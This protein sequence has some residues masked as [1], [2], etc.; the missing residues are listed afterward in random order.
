[1]RDSTIFEI[2]VREVINHCEWANIAYSGIDKSGGQEAVQTFFFVQTFMAHCATVARLLWSPEFAEHAGGRTIAKV[3]EVPPVYRL[4]DETV[5]EIVEHYDQR[6]A[7][8]LAARAEPRRIHD[9]NIGDRDAFEQP[10]DLFLRHY[11]PTVDAVTLIEEE[12]NLHHI[13]TEIADIGDRANKWI[14]AHAVLAVH[15]ARVSIPP[16]G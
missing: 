1:M 10:D 5:R 14:G 6:L 4:E 3:L 2:G 13:W 16:T 7:R 9:Y 11:D 8:G 12:F 15:P